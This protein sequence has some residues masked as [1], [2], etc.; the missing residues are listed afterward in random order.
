MKRKGGMLRMMEKPKCTAQSAVKTYTIYF[1][2]GS[3]TTLLI[4]LSG[5]PMA[6]DGTVWK[7]MNVAN[8]IKSIDAAVCALEEKRTRID[9]DWV[10]QLLDIAKRLLILAH[11]S[12]Y[13]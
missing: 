7:E 2:T 11:E 9:P 6:I 1:Q 8:L 5:C 3:A 12:A 13:T 10:P 4:F